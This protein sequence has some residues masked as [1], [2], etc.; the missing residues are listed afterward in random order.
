MEERSGRERLF[1]CFAFSCYRV[2][3]RLRTV[4]LSAG[5]GPSSERRAGAAGVVFMA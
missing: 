1:G 5:G 2:R 4:L 3:M